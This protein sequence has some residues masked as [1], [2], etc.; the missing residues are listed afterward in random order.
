MSEKRIK[1][2]VISD[3]HGRADRVR[4]LAAR[5]RDAEAILFLGDGV[6]DLDIIDPIP[7]RAICAVKGNCDMFPLFS[8][9]NNEFSEERSLIFGNYHILMMH[10]HTRGVKGGIEN[11]LLYAYSRGA[12]ILLFGHTHI[13]FEKYFPAGSVVDGVT[14]ERPMYAFN[15]GS[16]GESSFGYIEIRKKDILFSHGRV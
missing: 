8:N 15:P 16:L 12:D 13:P 9:E 5:Q 11:A 1:L 4:E 10:G 2:L 7:S 14:L 6:R 3:S